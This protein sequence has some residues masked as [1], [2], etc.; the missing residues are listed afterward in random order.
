MTTK[1][2]KNLLLGGAALALLTACGEQ[3]DRAGQDDHGD[4]LHT[5]AADNASDDTVATVMDANPLL[6]EW[7]T[8]FG[9]PPFSL[10]SDED[11]LPAFDQAITELEAEVEAIINN[12][13]APTFDNT[14]KA[15]E[16]SGATLTRVSSVFGNITNTDTNDTLQA[17][18][19]EIY[20]RL[21]KVYDGIALNDDLWA[22]IKTLY[23]TRDTLGLGKQELRVLELYHRDFVRRG[24]ALDP[25][26]KERMKEINAE[27]SELTTKFGQNLLAETKDFELVVTDEAD[28]A[29]LQQGFIDSAKKTAEGKGR[30]DAWIFGLNRSVYEGFMTQSENRD[31]RRQLFEG[32]TQRADNGGDTDSGEIIL[33]IARLRAEAARLRG[34]ENHAH[35]QLETRMAKTAQNTEEFLLQVWRPGLATAKTELAEMQAMV[36]ATDNPYKV[37]AW[38]WWHLSEKVRQEKYAFDD[39]QLKPYF[40]MEAVWDGAFYMAENLF[41]I[42]F[43]KL[44]DTPV[45]HPSVSVYDLQDA[46]GTHLGVFMVDMYARDS[47]RGGAWMSTYRGASNVDGDNIRPIVTNNLNLTR[48]ASDDAPTLMAFNEVETLFHEFGHGLHGLITTQNYDRIS[49]VGGPRDYTEFPAQILEHWAS[50]PEMLAVYAKH[51]ETGEVIP[52]EL[53][54]KL[55]EAANHNEGFRTTEFIAASLL[56]LRWHMLSEEEANAITDPREFEKEVLAEY[57]LIDEIE[58]RYRS[59]YFSH[60]FAGGYSAGYYAYL[61]SEILDSD[62]FDAFKETGDIFDQEVAGRLR[63][64]VYEAGAVEE[65]DELYR[66]FRGKDPS[67]EPLLRNRGF[68]DGS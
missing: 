25:E 40:E 57:G 9:I 59:P 58:P 67:I 55:K 36:D 4:E 20:P 5:E 44:E 1:F 28:L 34:Y 38:D 15:L 47:K 50:E 33:K 49:G 56:D 51:Y 23:E 65:A 31:L 10:V 61:W 37:E 60:I 66:K 48:P 41:G 12:P 39:S 18:E 45:W 6:Q 8:P 2:L 16:V 19:S 11:Y 53:V 32:Y 27:L 35:F 30:D 42:T 46:D 26:T 29:G 24:A 21:S 68:T 13:D 54:D 62:G 43:T 7:D 22:R 64:H 17:L 3:G 63:K 52:T 14:I